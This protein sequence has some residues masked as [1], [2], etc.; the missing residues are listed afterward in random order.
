MGEKTYFISYTT[1]TEAGKQWAKWTE[2]F[3]REKLGAKTI[4]QEYDFQPG[5]N[6]KAKMDDALKKSDCVVCVLTSAYLDS[7]NCT[8]EWTNAE[9]YILTK[10]DDCNPKG[11]LK[12]RSHIN[13][14]GLD[15]NTACQK[16]I[17][18]LADKVRP[19]NEPELTGSANEPEY[20][21][22]DMFLINNLPAINYLLGEPMR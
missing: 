22:A 13:L 7:T 4:M 6:F 14:F 3:F 2:W 18:G 19:K 11:L 17:E 16:L 10:F 15:N 8:E 20:P 12:S 21:A 5:D 9:L 1:R